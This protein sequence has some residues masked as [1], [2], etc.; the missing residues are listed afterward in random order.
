[1]DR[2]RFDMEVKFSSDKTGV[3][4]GYGAMFGN[5]DAGG[6]V[7]EKGVA[8][9]VTFPWGSVPLFGIVLRK[10][11]GLGAQAMAGGSFRAPLATLSWPTG[12]FGGMGLEGTQVRVELVAHVVDGLGVAG[13]VVAEGLDQHEQHAELG[14]VLVGDQLVDVDV[15]VWGV[16]HGASGLAGLFWWHHTSPVF[17]DG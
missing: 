5:V 14:V 9:A 3:F 1:M 6:D 7:I 16:V 8:D 15:E 17:V 12:E 13:Q 11:Y 4:S 2:L 10:G